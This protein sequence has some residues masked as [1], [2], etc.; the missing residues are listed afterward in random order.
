MLLLDH[1]CLVVVV[2]T[3]IAPLWRQEGQ[4]NSTVFILSLRSEQKGMRRKVSHAV[5]PPSRFSTL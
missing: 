1:S 5:L 4:D 3:D 2:L